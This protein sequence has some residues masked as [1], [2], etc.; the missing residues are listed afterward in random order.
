MDAGHVFFLIIGILAG[1][2]LIVGALTLTG[3]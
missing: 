1:A 2:F 3:V